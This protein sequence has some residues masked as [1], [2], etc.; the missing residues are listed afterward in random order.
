MIK[1][2]R[3]PYHIK[4]GWQPLCDV[5][6]GVELE[7]RSTPHVEGEETNSIFNELIS[8]PGRTNMGRLLIEHAREGFPSRKNAACGDCSCGEG[9]GCSNCPPQ[10]DEWLAV[11]NWLVDL[12]NDAT[13]GG[14]LGLWSDIDRH[15]INDLIKLLRRARDSAYGR[16]E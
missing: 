7:E 10:E 11:G 1:R 15:G 6:L 2:Q 14:Y 9:Q 5:Q 12:I 4:V 3:G 8:V 13:H 16:D